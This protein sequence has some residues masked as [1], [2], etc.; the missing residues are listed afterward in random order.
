[1]FTANAFTEFPVNCQ[2]RT[3][4]AEIQGDPCYV[5]LSTIPVIVQVFPADLA[6]FPSMLTLPFLAG[7]SF[8]AHV[9]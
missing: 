4:H 5:F 7:G 1:M 9:F 6:L 8:V 3:T 2:A